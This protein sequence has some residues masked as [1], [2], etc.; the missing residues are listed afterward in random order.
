METDATSTVHVQLVAP[1]Y[2]KYGNTASLYCNHTVPESNLHKIEFVKDDKKI[3]QYIKDRNTQFTMPVKMTGAVLEYSPDGKTIKLKD[4]TFDASGTYSCEVSMATP[5]Y[6]KASND[7]QMQVIV[8]QTDN[9]Q[10]TFKKA[11][12]EVGEYLEANC[13]SSPARPV[14]YL[15]WLINGKEVD[16]TLVTVYPHK[17]HNY[18]LMSSTAK[19]KIQVSELHAGENGHLEISCQSTI[20]D[21]PITHKQYADFRSRTVSVQIIPAVL[22]ISSPARNARQGF[23]LPTI[24][25][26]LC[27]VYRIIPL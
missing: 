7:V 13:T 15:T 3:L 6:A 11:V 17:Q 26:I 5:I 1:R 12:Y 16:V 23:M 18:G 19:L 27:G 2:V 10:I 24:M 21:Y 4:V 25:C 14:P 20:P 9:P 8:T 22:D